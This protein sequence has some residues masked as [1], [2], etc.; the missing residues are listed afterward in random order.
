MSSNPSSSIQYSPSTHGG[1]ARPLHGRSLFPRSF[2]FRR[3]LHGFTLVEL[4]VVITIIGILI[5]L[6]LPAV[7]AAREAARRMQCTNNLKQLALALH[8]YH[9]RYNAFP[10]GGASS[11]SGW[12][13][14]P[15]GGA[16]N[17]RTFILPEL[18]QQALY[19]DIKQRVRPDFVNGGS[20]SLTQFQSC[21]IRHTV[22]SGFGC[23]SDP[24]SLILVT[25][26]APGWSYCGTG[27]DPVAVSNYFGSGGPTSAG[28]DQVD[29]S[30]AAVNCGLCSKVTPFTIC[31]CYVNGWFGDNPRKAPVGVFAV[32][33]KSTRVDDISDGTSNTLLLQEQILIPGGDGVAPGMLV[34]VMEP[35]SVGTTVWGVNNPPPY[36]IWPS[37]PY[38]LAGISG[39]HPGG[40]NVAMADGSVQFLSQTI[41][42]MLLGRL[43]TRAGG[44]PI[45]GDY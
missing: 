34:Q 13:G 30:T 35:Y 21:L 32:Q 9:S 23:P 43:G 27:K 19:D 1:Q 7:Q 17:W 6:L 41:N 25:A 16:F 39:Y 42:L 22:L 11:A 2:S 44:E 8:T 12:P 45:G 37:A 3:P 38:Y 33:P 10:W 4:L 24:L 40:A 18:E 36:S 31:P 28:D 26:K 14:Y 20:P 29:P 15:G 5:A